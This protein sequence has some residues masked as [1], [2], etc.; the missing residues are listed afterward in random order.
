VAPAPP[1][2]AA[3]TA[4]PQ[5]VAT[6]GGEGNM[7]YGEYLEDVDIEDTERR[8]TGTVPTTHTVV[9][10]D[11]LWDLSA[12][13]FGNAWNWPKIWKLNPE[14]A[15]PHWIYP[16]NI[17][18][19]REAG[20]GDQVATNLKQNDE[21]SMGGPAIPTSGGGYGLRQTAYVDLDDLKDAGR[22]AGSVDEKALLATGDS[23]YIAYGDKHPE[24]GTTLA[25]Y[26][27][28]TKIKRD[29]KQ[30][31]AYIEVAGEL[32]VTFAEEGKRARAVITRSVNPVERGM[33]VGPLKLNFKNT[34]PVPSDQKVDGSVV[35]LIGPDELIGAEAAVIID[36][37]SDDGVKT[38]NRF[39]VVRRGD[40]Y[41]KVMR[42]GTNV[43]Q[44]DDEYPARA[45]GEILVLQTG[46]K[47][48]LGV[49]TFSIHEFGIG[50]RVFMRKGQ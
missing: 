41:S 2:P 8:H 22:I 23:V 13:Y 11:T 9:T 43:G 17:I 21:L 42:P 4:A 1:E 45:I 35:G 31:G 39:L 25:I 28:G 12:Y 34:K 7:F 36:R 38:G 33:R 26:G 48:C 37:G 10:G 5:Q 24:V 29:G 47:A 15:D 30:V 46:A 19:L 16:G 18:R 14:I 3:E 50:D 27:P 32:R 6:E 49:V 20:E 44:D 40:G